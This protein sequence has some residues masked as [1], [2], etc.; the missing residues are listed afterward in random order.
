MNPGLHFQCTKII[1][2]KPY[3]NITIILQFCRIPFSGGRQCILIGLLMFIKVQI[4]CRAMPQ[5]TVN[6]NAS[7]MRFYN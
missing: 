1:S 3:C 5:L 2:R 6:R 4:K 7:P